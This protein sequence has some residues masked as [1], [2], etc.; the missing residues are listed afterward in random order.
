MIEHKNASK[1]VI[2][3]KH[4]SDE[5]LKKSKF[6]LNTIISQ[7]LHLKNLSNRCL[8]DKRKP[9]FNRCQTMSP[10]IFDGPLS[11]PLGNFFSTQ[12]QENK[13]STGL[14]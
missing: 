3:L 2:K 5:L 10:L 13:I 9:L 4:P 8:N 1:Y 11:T 6:L 14:Y 7:Y 12:F